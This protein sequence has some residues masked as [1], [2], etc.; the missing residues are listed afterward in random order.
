MDI[1]S[2]SQIDFFQTLNIHIYFFKFLVF[3]IFDVHWESSNKVHDFLFVLNGVNPPIIDNKLKLLHSFG[4]IKYFIILE[5]WIAHNRYKHVKKQYA[6]YKCHAHKQRV[7]VNSHRVIVV[8]RRVEASKW[9]LYNMINASQSGG[10]SRCTNF[11]PSRW[12]CFVIK[13]HLVPSKDVIW[14]HKSDQWYQ[15]YNCEVPHISD[16]NKD[17]VY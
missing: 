13:F 7:D 15:V 5:E 12:W 2:H 1:L 9:R 10:I 4:G 17:D 16:Y 6:F 14:L 11:I 3:V 8:F